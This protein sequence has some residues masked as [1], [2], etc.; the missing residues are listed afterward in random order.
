MQKYKSIIGPSQHMNWKTEFQT[1]IQENVKQAKAE[2]QQFVK[3][4]HIIYLQQAGN[5]LFSAIENYLMLKYNKKVRSYK[6][7][8][9]LVKQDPTDFKLLRNAVQLHYF[10]YNREAQMD[11]LDAE[12]LFEEVLVN[13]ESYLTA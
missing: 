5:K 4:Q 1:D 11:R 13:I 9:A 10:F 2:Y 7:L 6:Q 8:Q 12:N 3:T